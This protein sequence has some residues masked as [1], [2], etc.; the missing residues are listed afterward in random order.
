[1]T[2]KPVRPPTPDPSARHDSGAD[3]PTVR[4]SFDV[5][6]YARESDSKVR[7]KDS[8]PAHSGERR[9]VPRPGF[10]PALLVVDADLPGRAAIVRGLLRERCPVTAVATL[11]ELDEALGQESFDAALVNGDSLDLQPILDTIVAVHET[12]PIVLL[13]TD[14]PR[15]MAAVAEA[16]VARS[17]VHGRGESTDALL[18]AVYTH[19]SSR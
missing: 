13:T 5:A 17:S 1:M 7:A 2:G 9:R 15:V 16:N 14:E 8:A 10:R 12:M 4:P 6:G 19:V 18:E 3:R 11:P